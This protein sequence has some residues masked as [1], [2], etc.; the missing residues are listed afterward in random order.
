[1]DFHSPSDIKELL[2]KYAT[3]PSKTMGQNFLTNKQV[4]D[5]IITAA[6]LT[7][8][9]TVIEI[10][11]GIG[12]LTRELSQHA[13]KVI[14]IEKDR[15]MLEI[16]KET[17]KEH[18]NINVLS[19]DILKTSTR[20]LVPKD[21]KVVANI[22]YYLT[23]ALIRKLLEEE[24]QPSEIILMIQ[25]EVAQRICSAPPDM[26]LLSVSVQFYATPEII[27]Y[28]SKESFWPAP[29]IDSAIIKITP[30]KKA[31]NTNREVFFKVVKAGFSHPRKQLAN[32]LSKELHKKREEVELWL[33]N[34]HI[35][36]TQRAETLSILD[37]EHLANTL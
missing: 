27:S 1:M 26:S 29:K 24:S 16:L 14:T 7:K 19:G 22:P 28:V 8:K 35:Q 25:K 17:L 11:P 34:N 20:D 6:N 33:L 18:S 10:G 31:P 32:N 30:H 2:S 21:Y 4:L 13:G 12:T 3:R 15:M 5:K 37:W 9:D 23:S 36:P